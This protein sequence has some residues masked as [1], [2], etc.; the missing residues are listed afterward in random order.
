MIAINREHVLEMVLVFAQSNL[1]KNRDHKVGIVIM[2]EDIKLG[3]MHLIEKY[4]IIQ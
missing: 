2:G 4:S 3:M 1:K